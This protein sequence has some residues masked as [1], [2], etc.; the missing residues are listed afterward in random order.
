MEDGEERRCD[1]KTN[2]VSHLSLNSSSSLSIS[3][4]VSGLFE[5]FPPMPDIGS[6]RFL[7]FLATFSRTAEAELTPTLPLTP[8]KLPLNLPTSLSFDIISTDSVLAARNLVETSLGRIVP[9]RDAECVLVLDDVLVVLGAE[10]KGATFEIRL[11]SVITNSAVEG[12]ELDIEV[13]IEVVVGVA[14]VAGAGVSVGGLVHSLDDG[15]GS[16]DTA[17]T[18][19]LGERE[20]EVEL[21]S[22]LLDVGVNRPDWGGEEYRSGE[23]GDGA[24][25]AIIVSGGRGGPFHSVS[26][27]GVTVIS[28]FTCFFLFCK[29]IEAF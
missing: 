13:D 7:T 15:G 3:L 20:G 9:V 16:D 2:D 19:G 8:L 23:G 28:V 18:E 22:D 4:T 29:G 10:E 12:A 24:W 5:V 27:S 21:V 11:L 25:T 1:T 6:D 14:F 17:E 26:H